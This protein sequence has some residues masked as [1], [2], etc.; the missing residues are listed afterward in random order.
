MKIDM[1]LLA[2]AGVLALANALFLHAHHGYLTALISGIDAGV[3][4][5]IGVIITKS[6]KK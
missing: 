5:W 6:P 4:L 1:N 3:F 2:L